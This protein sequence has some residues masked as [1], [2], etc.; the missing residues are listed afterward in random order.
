MKSHKISIIVP[1]FNQA[2]YLDACLKSVLDQTYTNWECLIINDGSTDSTDKIAQI[3]IEKDKR[4]FYFYKENG[5]LSSARNFGL[6]KMT[7]DFVQFLDSDDY[8]NN[9]KFQLS[10]EAILQKPSSRIVISNFKMF[11]NNPENNF[12]PYCILNQEKFTFKNILY[13]WDISFTI[14]IHC[15]FFE[16]S[17]FYDFR[18]PE[19]LFAKEDW[20]MWV[21]CFKNYPETIFIDQP[22]ALYRRNLDSMTMT[23]NLLPDTLKA[24]RLFKT[25]LSDEDFQKLYENT[26]SKYYNSTAQFKL[27]L[28]NIKNSNAFKF[29]NLI[30]KVLRKLKLLKPFR[31]ILS[32]IM[33]FKLFAKQ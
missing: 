10:I 16:K 26:I 9:E 21:N 22:L 15:G 23:K 6:E 5:G 18:F 31:K 14:P 20:V 33:S 28:I 27:N 3:W 12:P 1:C 11:E 7:G 2:Q 24:I 8:L 29:I 19:D 30:K 32:W 17:L 13:Q 25:I 4:F